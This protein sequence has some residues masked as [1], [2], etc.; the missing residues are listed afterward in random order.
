VFGDLGECFD[1]WYE[2]LRQ[3]GFSWNEPSAQRAFF[4]SGPD[5]H[6]GYHFDSSYVLAWQI[7]GRK[8]F[9]WLKEP[10]KWCPYEVRF[11]DADHYDRM[12]CPP[13]I[14]PDDVIECEMLPGDVLWNV[15]LTPHW[16]YSLDE[17]TYSFNLTHFDLRCDGELSPI[18]HELEQIRRERAAPTE[19]V[20]AGA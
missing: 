17:P 3:H 7:T 13:G 9:C 4:W 12:P 18:A 16:V 10:E 15:M 6:S 20:A 5:C 19:L 8:R 2:G 1:G 14:T 11:T